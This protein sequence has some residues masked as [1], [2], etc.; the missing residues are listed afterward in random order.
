MSYV[1]QKQRSRLNLTLSR[2]RRYSINQMNYAVIK[3]G[4][5]QYRVSED[6][7]LNV[8]KLPFE[9]NSEVVFGEVLLVKDKDKLLIGKPKIEK[10]KVSALVVDNFRDKKIRVLKYKAKSHYKRVIGHRQP[11]TR[12]KI[13]KIEVVR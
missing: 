11:L 13:V 9:K 3:T 1:S 6:E 4:G 2:T 12:V 8:E 7:I 10:A 5:K